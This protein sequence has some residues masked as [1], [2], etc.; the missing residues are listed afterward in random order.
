MH[1]LLD[2]LFANL[3]RYTELNRSLV[4]KAGFVGDLAGSVRM[5]SLNALIAATRLGDRGAALSAVADLM[6]QGSGRV[7]A[8]LGGLD[9]DIAAAVELRLDDRLAAI[10]GGAGSLDTELRFLRALQINGRVEA[11]HLDDAGAVE[12]LFAQIRARLEDAAVET[13]EFTGLATGGASRGSA[14]H[15]LRGRLDELAGVAERVG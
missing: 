13:D 5:F 1:D 7:G 8:L 9:G 14:A 3:A 11:A 4:S 6:G 15:E 2:G 12:S 10:A